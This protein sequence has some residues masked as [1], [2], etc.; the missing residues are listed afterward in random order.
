[1]APKFTDS[2]WLPGI[3]TDYRHTG[4]FIRHITAASRRRSEGLYDD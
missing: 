4:D 1:M 3:F 2:D